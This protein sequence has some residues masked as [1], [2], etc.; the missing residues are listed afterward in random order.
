M[1]YEI[2]QRVKCNGNPDGTIVRRTPGGYEVR[3]MD[4]CRHIGVVDVAEADLDIENSP[5]PPT[6]ED[7]YEIIPVCPGCGQPNPMALEDG[8][9]DGPRE[10]HAACWHRLAD[11]D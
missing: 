7:D 5:Q 3:L 4:G 2:G 11:D 1:E 9:V 6:Q 10:Y 8:A